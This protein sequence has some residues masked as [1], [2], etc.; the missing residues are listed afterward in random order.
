M[1]D[2]P[3]EF[4]ALMER[5]AQGDQRAV[6]ELYGK[7]HHVVIRCIRYHLNRYRR[8]RTQYDSIDFLQSVWTY[9]FS[10]PEKLHDFAVFEDFRKYLLKVTRHKLEKARRKHLDTQE[11]D[12]GRVCHL[13]DPDVEVLATAVADPQP[14]PAEQASSQEH[15]DSWLLPLSPRLRRVVVLLRDGL[16]CREIAARLGCSLRS[17]GRMV[18]KLRRAFPPD[19]LLEKLYRFDQAA[20]PARATPAGAAGWQFILCVLLTQPVQHPCCHCG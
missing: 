16:S 17:V 2:E 9:I 11:R 18:V 12:L 7:S 10:A 1:S 15:W 20:A 8:L 6:A 19:L 14:S 5:F 3:N 13:S 4:A